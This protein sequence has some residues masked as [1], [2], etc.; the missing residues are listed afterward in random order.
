MKISVSHFSLCAVLHHVLVDNERVS[1]KMLRS[2]G[3]LST[4]QHSH[5]DSSAKWLHHLTWDDTLL[6]GIILRSDQSLPLLLCVPRDFE[7][8]HYLGGFGRVSILMITRNMSCSTTSY[9][10]HQKEEKQKKLRRKWRAENME[11]KWDKF[12]ADCLCQSSVKYDTIR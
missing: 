8:G 12:L 10:C 1:D 5:L 11:W 7:P 9:K 3:S 2:P 4:W 6:V